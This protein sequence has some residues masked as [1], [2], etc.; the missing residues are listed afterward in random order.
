M[1]QTRLD[2]RNRAVAT[3]RRKADSARSSLSDVKKEVLKAEEA[4]RKAKTDSQRKIEE[5]TLSRTRD[6]QRR[7]EIAAVPSRWPVSGVGP[8]VLGSAV[9]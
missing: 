9:G 1:S 3:A 5:S 4:V 6:R 2:S 8:V 7:K